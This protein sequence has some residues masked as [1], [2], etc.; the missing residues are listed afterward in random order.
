MGLERGCKMPSKKST[1]PDESP[2]LS[3]LEQI[4]HDAMTS[5]AA[6]AAVAKYATQPGPPNGKPFKMA[7]ATQ[8]AVDNLRRKTLMGR[9]TINED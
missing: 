1:E 2:K 5:P 6:K 7:K 4:V 9:K 8:E 3:R